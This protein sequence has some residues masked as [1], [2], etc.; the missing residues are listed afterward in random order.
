M[1]PKLSVEMQR[2]SGAQSLQGKES[3]V[4]KT[5]SV[6]VNVTMRRVS[7]APIIR[8]AM[9]MLFIMLSFV[10][11]PALPY[12]FLHYLILIEEEVG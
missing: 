11:C 2:F 5:G 7:L 3:K 9:Q 10:A 12:Y 6:D 1:S 4:H 8:H